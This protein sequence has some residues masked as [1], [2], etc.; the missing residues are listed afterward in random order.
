MTPTKIFTSISAFSI[1][2]LVYILNFHAPAELGAFGVLIVF[3]LL[4]VMFTALSTLAIQQARL[5]IHRSRN[6]RGSE[7]DVSYRVSYYYASVVALAPLLFLSLRS[8]GRLNLISFVLVLILI[9]VV[10]LYVSRQIK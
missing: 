7:G 8:V 5:A 9:G 3:L 4:Y 2:A 6:L 1:V 10:S